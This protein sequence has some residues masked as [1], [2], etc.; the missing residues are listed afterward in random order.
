MERH[1]ISDEKD[2]ESNVWEEGGKTQMGGV[3]R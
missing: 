3:G 2:V 1:L